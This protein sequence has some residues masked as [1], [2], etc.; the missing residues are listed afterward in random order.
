MSIDRMMLSTSYNRNLNAIPSKINSNKI[1]NWK[2]IKRDVFENNKLN[3][4][5][6]TPEICSFKDTKMI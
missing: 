4:I 3:T 2:I 1:Q 6:K 5:I